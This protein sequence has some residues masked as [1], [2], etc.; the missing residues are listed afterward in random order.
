AGLVLVIIAFRRREP[1]W[2]VLLL[3]SGPLLAQARY[4]SVLA[5]AAVTLLGYVRLVELGT[6]L[7]G[8]VVAA[9]AVFGFLPY[10]WQRAFPFEFGAELLV[11]G[12]S[13]FSAG[14]FFSNVGAALKV[15]ALP[16]H[17][18]WAQVLQSALAVVAVA[19]IASGRLNPD[20]PVRGFPLAVFVAA[21][22]VGFCVIL[23]LVWGDLRAPFI[24]RLG[25]PVAAAIAMLAGLLAGKL[26]GLHGRMPLYA[27]LGASLLAVG[28]AAF[29]IRDHQY[30]EL[31]L[32]PG[33]N[34]SLDW[35]ERE[36]PGCRVLVVTPYSAFFPLHG[37]SVLMPHQVV[38]LA[39]DIDRRIAAG[40][41]Q[42]IV[43][44]HVMRSGPGS[45]ATPA[46]FKQATRV[47]A[48]RTAVLLIAPVLGLGDDNRWTN[49]RCSKAPP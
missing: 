46:L 26:A 9:T 23:A 41:I 29:A 36:R 20:K 32:G 25:L 16:E 33:L 5:G 45:S 47:Q 39:P 22:A 15:L 30:D 18:G 17:L 1:V 13:F 12:Q 34:A 24:T 43:A 35:L 14:Y 11:P 44:F 7:I 40:E 2:A 42:E 10:A 4:E 49:V 28:S 38:A 21:V 31:G 37:Y 19:A 48:N 27:M 8:R 6:P 3:V